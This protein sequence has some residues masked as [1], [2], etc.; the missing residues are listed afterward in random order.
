MPS[1]LCLLLVLSVPSPGVEEV[2]WL[3]PLG[4]HLSQQALDFRLGLPQRSH[5]GFAKGL[6]QEAVAWQKAAWTRCFP[7]V[8]VAL[9][10][11]GLM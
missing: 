7:P 11:A 10:V 4:L 1:V 5:L 6:L 8:A 9:S 3:G 2:G